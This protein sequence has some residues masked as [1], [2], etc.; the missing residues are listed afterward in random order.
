[1]TGKGSRG[2]EIALTLL[3]SVGWLSRDDLH[4]RPGHAGP[5]VETPEG[6]CLGLHKCSYTLVPHRGS[7]QEAKIK[8]LA[9]LINAPPVSTITGRKEGRLPESIPPHPG[10]GDGVKLHGRMTVYS[11]Y[12]QVFNCS[13]GQEVA[14]K[15]G[16][17]PGSSSG[18]SSEETV[19]ALPAFLRE[20]GPLRPW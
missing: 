17:S 16:L 10:A 6:Q 3:R 12:R 7:W 18:Q 2:S 15:T 11:P 14:V 4:N 8:K 5:A 19:G 9:G 1:M 20:S 13:G